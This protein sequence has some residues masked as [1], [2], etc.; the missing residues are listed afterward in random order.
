MKQNLIFILSTLLFYS[1]GQ[2]PEQ[3]TS[4]NTKNETITVRNAHAMAYHF[5]ES[6]VYLFGGASEKEVFSDLWAWKG[7][8]WQKIDVTSGPEQRT[9]SSLSYDK[10]NDR[11][12]LFGG[13]KV[14]FGEEVDQNNLLNDTW[15]FRNNEW[16]K[17]NP[18][19][20]PPARAEAAMVY[21]ENR[22]TMVLFGG[23]Y[24]NGGEYTP[25]GDT[26]EFSDD[27]WKLVSNEGP[28]NRHGVSLVYDASKRAVIL[29][30][31]NTIDKQYGENSGQTWSWDGEVWKKLDITQPEGIFNSA[32]VYDNRQERIIRFGGWNGESRVN[33][34]WIFHEDKWSK[35]DSANSPSPRNHT[36]MVY[37]E[38][39]NRVLLFGGHDLENVFGDT[40]EYSSDRWKKLIESEPLQR[41]FNG[42]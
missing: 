19:D 2:K 17:L 11:L 26:W 35:L 5:N 23:Y 31:G 37:D 30:G 7:E 38:S 42:H 10:K 4:F 13:S 9:F 22:Q 24:I 15:E 34:T 28:S 40:W 20:T 6:T 3:K 12:V 29:F 32:M 16:N 18:V 8:N 21:D 41:I 36:N 1:C 39:K 25:F 27:N 14:L 33:N